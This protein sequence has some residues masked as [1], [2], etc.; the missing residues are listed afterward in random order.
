MPL[1][2][3]CLS[4]ALPSYSLAPLFFQ[5]LVRN[6]G[7]EI[8]NHRRPHTELIQGNDCEHLLTEHGLKLNGTFYESAVNHATQL[9][10]CKN[11]RFGLNGTLGTIKGT[12]TDGTLFLGKVLVVDGKALLMVSASQ[13]EVKY[14]F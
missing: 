13:P 5:S 3:L 8:K 9:K 6:G 7:E 12:Y 14:F 10:T 11:T 2:F 4:A 1:Y